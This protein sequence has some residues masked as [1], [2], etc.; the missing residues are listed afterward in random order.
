[1]ISVHKSK[2]HSL[3]NRMR[4]FFHALGEDLN[5]S[6]TKF[7]YGKIVDRVVAF[8]EMVEEKN[9]EFNPGLLCLKSSCSAIFLWRRRCVNTISKMK[10][11]Q[12]TIG[13]S[14][15]IKGGNVFYEERSLP[16]VKKILLL[17]LFPFIEFAL[18]Y[19]FLIF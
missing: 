19:K 14:E 16:L 15:F 13:E 8:L 6:L 2:I 9:F 5:Q 17:G 1:M 12:S 7:C 11:S 4:L 18:L 10:L 3:I